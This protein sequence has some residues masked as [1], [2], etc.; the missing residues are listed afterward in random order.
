MLQS[1][2]ISNYALIDQLDIAFQ[3]GFNIITGETGA[4]KSIMLGAL[5]LILGGRA[6]TKVVRDKDKKSV[7]EATFEVSDYSTLKAY[8][9]AND[10]EWDDGMCILRREIA[11]AGR[12]RAFINDSPVTLVQLETV[13]RQLID[14]HS[15]HQNQLLQDPSY[16]LRI[17]DSLAGNDD[18]LQEYIRRFKALRDARRRYAEARERIE[19]T[20]DDEEFL[21][22]QLQQLE[23]LH[24]VD[25]EQEELER[26]RELLANMSD[27]KSALN[28]VLDALTNADHNALSCLSTAVEGCEELSSVLEEADSLAERLESARV[29][30]QDVAETLSDYDSDLQADPLELESVEDRLNA[31]YALQHRHKVSSVS[32]L[33]ALRDSLR[34]RLDDIDSSD[35][36]LEELQREVKRA[37]ALARE[38]A[39]IISDRRK[40]EAARF[41]LQLKERALPLGMKNIQCEIRVD[42][43]DM[44]ASGVDKVE[45]LFA[46]NKNQPLLPVGGTASGGEISRLMLSIKAIIAD[47]MQLPSIIFDEVDTGVSG[48]VANRMGEMM[49]EISRNIQ[50]MSITHLPQVAAKGDA[51]YK[52]FKEDDET[53]TRTRIRELSDSERISELALMLSGSPDDVAARANAES[54]LGSRR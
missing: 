28:T 46:F 27:I 13:G 34:E 6:D 5:S 29:E 23:A 4:G 38:T 44:N 54:L 22:F 45:F 31:I 48:D 18:L 30:I 1:L 21:R 50:V 53:A 14:I 43:D 40:T 41:A 37:K 2:H 17:I 49:Q 25:G 11:P 52:V 12:S 3:P 32:E 51:H 8:C 35:N 15:Q 42:R 19:K 7:I 26:Q 9:E 20:R 39:E 36:T 16:Q 33:I 24:L 10:V 47:K